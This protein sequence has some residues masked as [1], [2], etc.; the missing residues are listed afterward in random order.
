[1]TKTYEVNLKSS[2][3]GSGVGC[4]IYVLPPLVLTAIVLATMCLPTVA[5]V[6][7]DVMILAAAVISV[8]AAYDS[9]PDDATLECTEDRLILRYGKKEREMLLKDIQSVSYRIRRERYSE[10]LVLDIVSL[11]NGGDRQKM[12]F[13]EE[14][15]AEMFEKLMKGKR[16]TLMKIYKW[17]EKRKPEAAYGRQ[18]QLLYH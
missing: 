18:D 13:E 10:K 8:F 14:T 12:S 16:S 5:A 11:E 2:K 3:F 15:D 9:V 1:M 7:I 17:I 4:L 6:I